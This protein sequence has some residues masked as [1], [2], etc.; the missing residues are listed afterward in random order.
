MVSP[1][2]KTGRAD[3]IPLHSVVLVHEKYAL[4]DTPDL[5]ARLEEEEQTLMNG[6]GRTATQ[7]STTTSSLSASKRTL[8]K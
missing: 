6:S 7:G 8:T 1:S 2:Q 3:G 5:D 4:K